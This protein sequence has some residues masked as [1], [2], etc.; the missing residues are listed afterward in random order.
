MCGEDSIFIGRSVSGVPLV[1]ILSGG[2]KELLCHSTRPF[3]N[4]NPQFFSFFS[5]SWP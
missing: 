1:V 2:A 3:S 5:F 4:L